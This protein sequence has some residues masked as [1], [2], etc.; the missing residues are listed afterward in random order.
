LPPEGIVS[1]LDLIN[2][3]YAVSGLAV[4]FIVGL[5]GVGGGSLMTPLLILLFG[6]HPA[7]AVG[8]DLLY[9]GLTKAVGTAVHG[10]S[11]SVNWRIVAWLASGSVPA[12]AATLLALQMLGPRAEATSSL[13]SHVLGIALLAT[14]ASLLLRDRII[15]LAVASDL[16]SE[17]QTML[18]VLV[19]A[20]V[21]ALVSISSVGAGAI[22]VTALYFLYPRLPAKV[23][24]GSD[25]AHAVPLTLVA[26]SGYWLLGSIDWAMLAS[27]LI[28]SVPG[29]IAGSASAPRIPDAV[30]R[31]ILAT[32]LALV[33][34]RLVFV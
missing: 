29:I 6:V 30:L 5:T 21:G 3:L 2:P 7:T 13:I 20:A 18:T 28:G 15:G 33:G 16:S 14:A 19:G 9:A 23:L 31:P 1:V 8:T 10:R 11:G 22:G 27:L 12:S 17:R 24:I 26:G 4:G 25:I 34:A 32:V